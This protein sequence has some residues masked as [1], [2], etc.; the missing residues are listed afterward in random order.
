MNL[1]AGSKVKQYAK[2]PNNP[3]DK[4]ELLIKFCWREQKTSRNKELLEDE[5]LHSIWWDLLDAYEKFFHFS[6]KLESNQKEAE[7]RLV[8]RNKHAYDSGIQNI[9]GYKNIDFIVGT[10]RLT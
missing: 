6:F 3:M 4:K 7:A 1:N 2:F 8:L 10:R 5:T 9:L